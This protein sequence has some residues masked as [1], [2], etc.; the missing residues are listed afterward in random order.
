M[1]PEPLH[2][3]PWGTRAGNAEPV[4]LGGSLLPRKPRLEQGCG[5]CARVERRPL[6]CPSQLLPGNHL[7]CKK[8]HQTLES[9]PHTNIARCTLQLVCCPS[10]SCDC[11]LLLES[12][13][14]RMPFLWHLG[15]CYSQLFQNGCLVFSSLMVSLMH[16]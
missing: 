7:L 5:L 11:T 1:F 10:A 12:G 8:S 9:L 3:H 13:K 15:P 4:T 16:V 14:R 2:P 6:L